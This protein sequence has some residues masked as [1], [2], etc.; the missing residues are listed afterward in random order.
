MFKFWYNIRKNRVAVEAGQRSKGLGY[1]NTL[2]FL[3]LFSLTFAALKC[4]IRL[5]SRRIV[6]RT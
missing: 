2:F 4:C 6:V 1:G 3:F 5:Y